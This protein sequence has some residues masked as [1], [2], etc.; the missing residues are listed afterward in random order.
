MINQA[1]LYVEME[2]WIEGDMVTVDYMN[3]APDRLGSYLNMRTSGTEGYTPSPIPD[4]LYDYEKNV[5]AS[6]ESYVL[7][8]NGYLNRSNGYYEL[9]ISSYIQQ[10]MKGTM[11]K[12]ILLGPSGYDFMGYGQVALKG[13]G[14]QPMRLSITYTLI[15]K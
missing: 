11:K 6:D 10:I 4:Y 9:N 8:Y 14:A 12:D 3:A 2:N 15:K 13:A 5:Q 7:P 1:M